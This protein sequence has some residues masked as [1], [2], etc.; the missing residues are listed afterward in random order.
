MSTN[1]LGAGLAAIFQQKPLILALLVQMAASAFAADTV[2]PNPAAAAIK[3][4]CRGILRDGVVAIGGET[5]GTTL[6]FGRM[7]WDLSLTDDSKKAFAKEH[8]KKLV[9]VTGTLKKVTGPQIPVRWVID[10]DR[11]AEPKEGESKP[12][13]SVTV[14]GKLRTAEG[15]ESESAL[16]IEAQGIQ[17]PLDFKEHPTLDGKAQKLLQ[18]AVIVHGNFEQTTVP[19]PS[20]L[21][22]HVGELDAAPATK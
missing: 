8:N 18:K 2:T 9:A 13:T 16:F 11:F 19:R 17:W 6:S 1:Q 22:I 20:Q 4:E 7:T 14:T 10:V 15:S 5:T 21:L 3:V 12:M